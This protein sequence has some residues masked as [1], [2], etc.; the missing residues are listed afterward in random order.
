[1]NSQSSN[2]S[3]QLNIA[4]KKPLSLGEVLSAPVILATVA[5]LSLAYIADTLLAG[6]AEFGVGETSVLSR[7]L[8]ESGNLL[9][10]LIYPLIS[11]GIALVLGGFGAIPAGLLGGMLTGTGATFASTNANATSI[12]GIFGCIFAGFVAGYSAK[13][14]NKILINIKTTGEAINFFLI[15][16]LSLIV[17]LPAVL[18]LNTASEY[19]NHFTSSLAGIISKTNGIL[20]SVIL[21]IFMTAD[22]GG[23]LYLAGYTFGVASI[24][25][26]EPK[27]MATIIAAG[28]IPPIT[29]GLYTIIYKERTQRFERILGAVG[30]FGGLLGLPHSALAFYTKKS[31]RFLLACVPGGI[32]ASILSYAFNC[33]SEAPAGGILG[34]SSFGR[35]LFLLLALS[36]GGLLSTFLLSLTEIYEYNTTPLSNE[37]TIE[38]SKKLSP[39]I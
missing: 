29:M 21:G 15:P 26:G 8:Y 27:Y 22:C 13:I 11:S 25:T 4:N 37:N 30:I 14:L 18:I 6:T 20:L 35:P 7:L 9:S 2:R 31:Y 3:E 38:T 17:V 34:F 24:A 19:L 10:K 16:T 5:L 33:S 39:Q 28:A 36:C 23:P 1:M 12:S 32:V